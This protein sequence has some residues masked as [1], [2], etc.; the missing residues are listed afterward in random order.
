MKSSQV[1]VS[2]FLVAVLPVVAQELETRPP[3]DVFA[4]FEPLKAPSSAGLLLKKGDRLAIIGDSITEQKM[5]SRVM[6]TYLTV[7]VPDLEVTTRQYGWG[8]ETAEGFVRRMTNDCLRFNPTIATTCPCCC[9]PV[10]KAALSFGSTSLRKSSMPTSCATACAVRLASP[11]CMY[12]L[13][14]A[15]LSR[16]MACTALGL[17]RSAMDTAARTR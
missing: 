5:Y 4:K 1:F 8:G 6:E 12:T 13:M 17:I 14:P 15:S 7:C 3:G 16:A 10:T 9:K 2:L 11:V